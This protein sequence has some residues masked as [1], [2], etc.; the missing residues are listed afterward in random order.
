MT[1]VAEMV[2]AEMVVAV[3]VVAVMA[4]VAMDLVVKAAEVEGGTRAARKVQ[5]KQVVT[6]ARAQMAVP[7]VVKEAKA[8]LAQEQSTV[9]RCRAQ[10]VRCLRR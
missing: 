3:M 7:R 2:V 8:E 6:M 4:K 10:L 5:V 1:V 9:V